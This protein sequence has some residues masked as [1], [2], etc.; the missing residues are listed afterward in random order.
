MHIHEGVSYPVGKVEIL[1]L[2]PLNFREFLSAMGEDGLVEALGSNDYTL[3]DSFADK[4]LF[5]QQKDYRAVREIQRDIVRQY[6]GDFGKH[7][8]KYPTVCS[9]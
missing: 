4:Y 9:M 1:D 6:Q 7:I 8:E 5:R 3:I 2:Y